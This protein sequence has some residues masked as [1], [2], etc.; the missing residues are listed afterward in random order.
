MTAALWTASGVC[1]GTFGKSVWSLSEPST[2]TDQHGH[3]MRPAL[4]DAMGAADASIGPPTGPQ[5]LPAGAPRARAMARSIMR[6]ASAV[7][8][9]GDASGLPACMLLVGLPPRKVRA[10]GLCR[11]RLHLPSEDP[12]C[13][14][15]AK[16]P[17]TPCRDF[18]QGRVCSTANRCGVTGVHQQAGHH[19]QATRCAALRHVPGVHLRPRC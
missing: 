14:L 9:G 5:H 15:C 8:A 11:H 1:V 16:Q 19:A 12:G 6:R 3:R 13:V 17:L 18:S 10:P 4:W 7:N 2:W